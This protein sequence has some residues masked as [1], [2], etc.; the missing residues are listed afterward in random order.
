MKGIVSGLFIFLTVLACGQQDPASQVK[1]QEE[2]ESQIQSHDALMACRQR[3]RDQL[4][5]GGDARE[6]I[7]EFI[8]GAE[9][10]VRAFPSDTLG[11]AFLLEAA[12]LA[13]GIGKPGSSIELWGLLWRN[14]PDHPESPYAMFMQA[15]VFETTIGDTINARRYFE[16]VISTYPEHPLAAS[17]RQSLSALGKSAKDLIQQIDTSKNTDHEK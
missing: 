16:K 10:Y 2:T 7:L 12:Q 4:G 14:H 9:R 3:M 17:A 1:A 13:G 8:E 5:K 15:F 6:L 11:P